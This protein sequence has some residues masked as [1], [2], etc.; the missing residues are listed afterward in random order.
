MCP[1]AEAPC[2]C[3]SQEQAEQRANC[4]NQLV[5]L[6]VKNRRNPSKIGF[7]DFIIWVCHK[8]FAYRWRVAHDYI[9]VLLEIWRIDKWKSKVDESQYLSDEEKLAW[10]EWVRS[11]WG[12]S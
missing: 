10:A 6:C 1:S 12:S 8:R 4:I 11:Q 3:R 9:D 2:P 5:A 7:A